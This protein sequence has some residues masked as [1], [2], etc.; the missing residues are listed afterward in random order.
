M[1]G[2]YAKQ[3]PLAILRQGRTFKSGKHKTKQL[4]RTKPLEG[5]SNS[6]IRLLVLMINTFLKKEELSQLGK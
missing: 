1:S 3:E 4:T 6:H 2:K 5:Y